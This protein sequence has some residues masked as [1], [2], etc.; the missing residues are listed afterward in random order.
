MTDNK[1]PHTAGTG[2]ASKTAFN[3]PH[4][5]KDPLT[6]WYSLGPIVKPSRNDRTPK[7]GWKRNSRGRIDPLL[8]V[9][10]GLLALAALLIVGG[11]YA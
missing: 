5:T 2:T 3:D 4:S 6:G 7:R 1:K 8:A 11:N 10:I 9:H